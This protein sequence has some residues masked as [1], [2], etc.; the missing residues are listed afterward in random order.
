MNANSKVQ[1]P[2]TV[3]CTTPETFTPPASGAKSVEVV[4]M[5]ATCAER[6]WVAEETPVALVYNGI[7]HAVMMTS[8]S[9]LEAFALGFSLTEGIIDSPEEILDIEVEPACRGMQVNMQI[10]SS[11]FWRLKERRRSLTGRTG[12]GLC[13]VDS[14]KGAIRQTPVVK[15]TQ[16]FDMRHYDRAVGYLKQVQDL[17]LLTGCTHAAVWVN[18]DGTLAAGAEDVGR[19]VA[20]DKLLGMRARDGLKDGILVISSRA[21][22][23]M[24]Q[25][26]AMCGVEIMFAVSAPTALAVEMA[27]KSG[28]TLAAFCRHARMNVYAHPER[29]I[30]L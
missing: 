22:Y 24:V 23:E 9:N 11:A 25:K 15:N 14:L 10:P 19:H 30:G 18:P 29:L 12:C 17:G 7:S 26:A 2:D 13:G 21:S 1:T 20:L 4:R 5:N 28:I 3:S 16:T 8:P 27:Q 6:D